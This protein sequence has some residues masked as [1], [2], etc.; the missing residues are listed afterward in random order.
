MRRVPAVVLKEKGKLQR[1]KAFYR[2]SLLVMA[3]LAGGLVACNSVTIPP[4][5]GEDEDDEPDNPDPGGESTGFIIQVGPP[6]L[7]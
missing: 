2:T 7:V 6:I 5:P 3:A 1:M 4:L